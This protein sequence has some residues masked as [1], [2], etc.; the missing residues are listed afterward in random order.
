MQLTL[1]HQPLCNLYRKPQTSSVSIRGGISW[2][3]NPK[4]Y[5]RLGLLRIRALEF[6]DVGFWG[7]G[8]RVSLVKDVEHSL[9]QGLESLIQRPLSN[10][11]P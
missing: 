9:I 1:N 8:L 5:L 4:P 10:P 6:R 7:F 3:L 2:T 11:E